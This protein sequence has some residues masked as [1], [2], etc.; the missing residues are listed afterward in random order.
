MIVIL[1]QDATRAQM[2][3]VIARIEQMGCGVEVSH[4]EERTIIGVIGDGRTNGRGRTDG[5]YPAALQ[6]RQPRLSPG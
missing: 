6:A 1:N 5:A 2:D 4:G 3:N